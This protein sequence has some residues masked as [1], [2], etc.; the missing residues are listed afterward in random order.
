MIL[1]Y[2]NDLYIGIKL[3]IFLFFIKIC[4]LPI[5]DHVCPIVD[6]HTKYIMIIQLD[7]LIGLTSAKWDSYVEYLRS[8][9]QQSSDTQSQSDKSQINLDYFDILI[10]QKLAVINRNVKM[11]ISN[12]KFHIKRITKHEFLSILE[13][14]FGDAIN[15]KYRYTRDSKLFESL[16]GDDGPYRRFRWCD[17]I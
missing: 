12:S 17:R 9:N 7:D 16:M 10:K 5:V 6:I 15:F 8:S 2:F 11:K 3:W 4:I 14:E 13:T 1:K